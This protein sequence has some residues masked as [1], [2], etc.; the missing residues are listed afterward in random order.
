MTMRRLLLL[1]FSIVTVM[2]GQ[3]KD[4]AARRQR[5]LKK[6]KG[7]KGGKGKG[8]VREAFGDVVRSI[9]CKSN[10]NLLTKNTNT[11]GSQYL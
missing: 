4:G 5:R 7:G 10:I 11:L 3:P 2:A 8:G 9:S 1:S 6:G